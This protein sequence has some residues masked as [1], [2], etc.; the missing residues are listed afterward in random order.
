MMSRIH[1]LADVMIHLL[2]RPACLASVEQ[3]FSRL[4]IYTK[5]RNWLGVDRAAKLVFCYT[6]PSYAVQLHSRTLLTIIT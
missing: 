4:L 2:S 3:V 5:L 1:H 6:M